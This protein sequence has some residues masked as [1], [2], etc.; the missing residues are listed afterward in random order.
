MFTARDL[1]RSSELLVIKLP[2]IFTT[3]WD[4]LFRRFF[5]HTIGLATQSHASIFDKW[6]KQLF[7]RIFW[8]SKYILFARL[9]SAFLSADIFSICF[10]T[11]FRSVLLAYII[12]AFGI[13]D[14]VVIPRRNVHKLCTGF[15]HASTDLL[16]FFISDRLLQKLKVLYCLLI[17]RS[18]L[19]SVGFDSDVLWGCHCIHRLHPISFLLLIQA[20]FWK[21]YDH[22]SFSGFSHL[23]SDLRQLTFFSLIFSINFFDLRCFF[24]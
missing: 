10:K 13:F 18:N 15:Y 20:L 8:C 17:L 12:E 3:G 6:F 7:G 23:T 16:W 22:F 2:A 4:V 1:L 9:L 19:I 11:V 5:I 21:G 14:C 24:T